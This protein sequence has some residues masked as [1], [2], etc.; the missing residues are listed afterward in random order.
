M[1]NTSLFVKTQ[2]IVK[3]NIPGEKMEAQYKKKEWENGGK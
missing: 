1:S 2:A 3:R